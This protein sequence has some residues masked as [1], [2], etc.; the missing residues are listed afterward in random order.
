VNKLQ[1]NNMLEG[2]SLADLHQLQTAL[3]AK[4]VTILPEGSS[5]GLNKVMFVGMK[6]VVDHRKVRGQVG[7]IIKINRTRCKVKFEHD[8]CY[9]VPMNMIQKA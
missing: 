2:L 6:C 8:F 7:E 1:I 9:N 4:I 5:S 3:S